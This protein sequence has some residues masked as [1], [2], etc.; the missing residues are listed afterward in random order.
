[1]CIPCFVQE[2]HSRI[3][4]EKEKEENK[5][6]T[7][8]DVLDKLV[9]NRYILIWACKYSTLDVVKYLISKGYDV[10]ISKNYILQTASIMGKLDILKYFITH[11]EWSIQDDYK[12]ALYNSIYHNQLD[13]MKLLA[14]KISYDFDDIRNEYSAILIAV[15]RKNFLH[16]VRY[17][18]ENYPR[19]I[20]KYYHYILNKATDAESNRSIVKYLIQY[21]GGDAYP[22]T[23]YTYS[24]EHIY[25]E[26]KNNVLLLYRIH[27]QKLPLEL[28]NIIFN[29]I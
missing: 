3:N 14:A 8:I 9:L 1:M 6:L 5:D 20:S 13:I 17:I 26:M 2:L 21:H 7:I 12:P 19:I 11:F 18:G 29:Y 27:N 23:P 24:S 10:H 25:L 16:I 4:E 28:Q 22:E 15:K